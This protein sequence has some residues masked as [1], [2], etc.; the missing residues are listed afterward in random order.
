VIDLEWIASTALGAVLGALIALWATGH[1]SGL[2]DWLLGP[3][4][5][6]VPKQVVRPSTAVRIVRED[7]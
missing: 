5:P 1:L 4:E 2:L 6:E 7:S 3:E